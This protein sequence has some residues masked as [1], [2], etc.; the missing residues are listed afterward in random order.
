MMY[1][2]AGSNWGHRDTILNK[3]AKK[4]SLGIVTDGKRLAFVEQFAGEYIEYYVPSTLSGSVLAVSG[5]FTIPGVEIN[6]ISITY[7]PL[8]QTITNSQLTT[9]A[10]Y[11]G[12]YGLGN[13]VNFII[14]PP[15]PGQTYASLSPEAIQASKWGISPSGQFSIQAG[16]S[17]ALGK[18]KGVY[19]IV[20]VAT[21]GG[22]N[23]NL[24]NYSI[25]VK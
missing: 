7:D 23:V 19:T 22:E 18:G 6:N 10:A 15:P 2:D 4:V 20:I 1:D 12:G 11:T 21:V 13:R 16:I 5:R 9:D 3:W 25:I 17:R 8:P 14:P 24:A